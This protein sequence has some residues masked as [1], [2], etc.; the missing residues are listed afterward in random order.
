MGAVL[1]ISTINYG[2]AVWLDFI[3]YLSSIT[4][5]VSFIKYLPQVWINYKR[6]STQ[7]WSIHYIIWVRRASICSSM[8]K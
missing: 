7:G 8:I 2:G 4:S 3:Y 6:Q 5:I 1:V